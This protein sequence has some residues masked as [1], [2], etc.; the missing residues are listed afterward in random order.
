[1]GMV[2]TPVSLMISSYPYSVKYPIE[3]SKTMTKHGL[4]EKAAS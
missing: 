4:K 3:E 1:M 2:Y